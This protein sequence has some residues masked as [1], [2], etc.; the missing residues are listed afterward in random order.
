M[1][2]DFSLDF[3]VAE[4][5]HYNRKCKLQLPMCQDSTSSRVG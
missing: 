1:S 2:N 5:H 3:S 4:C